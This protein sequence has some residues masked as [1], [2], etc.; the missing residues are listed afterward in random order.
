MDFFRKKN[1]ILTIIAL[2]IA[3]LF[4]IIAWI[5]CGVNNY[6]TG[7]FWLSAFI[8]L[9]LFSGIIIGFFLPI[10]EKLSI[11]CSM[12][13]FAYLFLSFVL[14]EPM[15][16]ASLSQT[17]DGLLKSILVFDGLA[18][19]LSIFAFFAILLYF[20]LPLAK[21]VTGTVSFFIVLGVIATYSLGAVLMLF[22]KNQNVSFWFRGFEMLARCF[23]L[24]GALFAFEWAEHEIASNK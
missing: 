7:S 22:Y 5:G 11:A 17:N 21:K 24:L 18:G 20:A 8:F 16:F 14:R 6:E 12:G 3:S 19:L 1:R 23:A 4:F 10:L 2:G 13:L 15:S 9:T